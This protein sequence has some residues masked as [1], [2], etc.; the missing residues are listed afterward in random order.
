M[1]IIL[2]LVQAQAAAV[3]M[4]AAVAQANTA[5][6]PFLRYQPLQIIL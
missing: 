4:A 6:I 3:A 5:L 1:L 2:S